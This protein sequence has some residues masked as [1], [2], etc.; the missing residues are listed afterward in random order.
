MVKK[1]TSKYTKK[2]H[3]HAYARLR[4]GDFLAEIT[5]RYMKL[6]YYLLTYYTMSC[7]GTSI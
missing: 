6:I 5:V 2:T 7:S 3:R 1:Q 4:F